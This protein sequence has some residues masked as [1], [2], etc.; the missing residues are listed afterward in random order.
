MRTNRAA[1]AALVAGTTLATASVTTAEAA[2]CPFGGFSTFSTAYNYFAPPVSKPRKALTAR[3][4]DRPTSAKAQRS[5]ASAAK[6]E[7]IAGPANV[8]AK[9]TKN[10][11]ATTPRPAAVGGPALSSVSAP[12]SKKAK[13]A[14]SAPAEPEVSA[15]LTKE[16]LETGAVMFN[17]T[18]TKEWAINSTHVSKRGAPGT[19]RTCLSKDVHGNGV[20]VFKDNCTKEWGMN[21]GGQSAESQ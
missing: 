20:V 17:D 21:T 16:Y 14:A 3:K 10:T 11:S 1:L 7:K 5:Y 2:P 9:R 15:C 12:A 6:P 19:S 8:P 18:C 4:Y 13:P